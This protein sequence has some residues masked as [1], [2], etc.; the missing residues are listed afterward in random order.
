MQ[1]PIDDFLDFAPAYLGK[2]RVERRPV[3]QFRVPAHHEARHGVGIPKGGERHGVEPGNAFG[4]LAD[5]Q[6]E[7]F[8]A[9][10]S[11]SRYDPVPQSSHVHP[12]GVLRRGERPHQA[13][14]RR[15]GNPGAHRIIETTDA[16]D[17]PPEDGRPAQ[18]LRDC[19]RIY[20]QCRPPVA[21]A[22]Q[23]SQLL[24]SNGEPDNDRAT[25]RPDSTPLEGRRALLTDCSNGRMRR[26]IAQT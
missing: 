20:V 21:Q 13:V 12:T 7:A 18:D 25:A 1:A 11:R 24:D 26:A 16:R 6:I 23:K 15:L 9:L 19:R 10:I 17:R 4:S 3:M 14:Q 5:L 22:P 8:H 2:G